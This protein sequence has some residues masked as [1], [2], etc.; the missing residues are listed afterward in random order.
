MAWLERDDKAIVFLFTPVH[1]SWLN[2][3]EIWF[4]VLARRL[5]RRASFESPA[6]LTE[7]L[8]AFITYYNQKL[9]H[10]YK[11]RL[12]RPRPKAPRDE[13]HFRGSAPW[14][15]NSATQN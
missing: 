6:D 12:W 8:Y 2:P 4:S 3:I 7:R 9:A 10:P 14:V 15:V 13:A 11:L 1:A 5:L